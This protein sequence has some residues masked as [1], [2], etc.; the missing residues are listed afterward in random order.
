M[1][2]EFSLLDDPGHLNLF[3]R[4]L[5]QRANINTPIEQRA[6]SKADSTT[7]GSVIDG[8]AAGD[9][10]SDT[11]SANGFDHDSSKGNERLAAEDPSFGDDV[12]HTDEMDAPTEK[13]WDRP[14]ET[15][16]PDFGEEG[17]TS[18]TDDLIGEGGVVIAPSTPTQ[19]S[20]NPF[21]P[22]FV[23]SS[24][25]TSPE[26]DLLKSRW[27]TQQRIDDGSS[28]SVLDD[29]A[30][31]KEFFIKA[32]N[33]VKPKSL[34]SQGEDTGTSS[35]ENAQAETQSYSGEHSAA[36]SSF[37]S[38]DV[39]SGLR[40]PPATP[41]SRAVG[42]VQFQPANED[43]PEIDDEGLGEEVN[44]DSQ[45]QVHRRSGGL[46]QS[47]HALTSY[48]DAIPKRTYEVTRPIATPVGGLSQMTEA[49]MN[50]TLDNNNNN[51]IPTVQSRCNGSMS[52]AKENTLRR[53]S[54]SYV[55]PHLRNKSGLNIEKQDIAQS[56]PGITG[57]S[58]WRAK[59]AELKI[60]RPITDLATFE[61]AKGEQ[62][63]FLESW[64]EQENRH[65]PAAQVRK[66][67]IKGLPE[68]STPAFVAGLVYGGP[69]ESVLTS[70]SGT[71][72]YVTFAYAEDARKYYDDTANGVAF[73][74]GKEPMH[75]TVEL[76]ADVTPIGGMVKS[77]LD[78]EYTR[79][80]GGIG[81]AENLSLREL[82][83]M[84][85]KKNRQVEAV[86]IGSTPR[87]I[88][89]VVWR[90]CRIEHAVSFK[91]ELSHDE[92]WEP[93]NMQFIE[94]PCATATG[95][96]IEK[97]NKETRLLARPFA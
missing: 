79:C 32:K 5:K 84:A 35:I 29:P 41:E 58:D 27:A 66:V 67:I 45:S 63:L 61:K 83:I 24:A 74:N 77:Y 15:Q 92:D 90:F 1:A 64:P 23:P 17:D 4:K 30:H 96:H 91:A 59:A 62:G 48:L 13:A 12:Q 50:I 18:T 52:T 55:A 80:V 38:P 2:D 95:I 86:E 40:A 78:K 39:G 57:L 43:I 81:V 31:L 7:A 10:V 22:S 33:G 68:A 42:H 69:L 8:S 6:S 19:A 93:V 46:D 73:M 47:M 44:N 3:F 28:A 87:G 56:P 49:A 76:I 94:D 14:S 9:H 75:A 72:A 97:A 53:T 71:I 60:Y 65:R 85:E 11:H 20:F 70:V 88:R 36:T 16:A 34:M 54:A 51:N 26:G 37:Q 25:M 21:A 89:L 82:W